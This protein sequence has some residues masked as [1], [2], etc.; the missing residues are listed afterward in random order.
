MK[1]TLQNMFI[2][3]P[4]NETAKNGL[5]TAFCGSIR[6]PD[7]APAAAGTLGWQPL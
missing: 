2:T 1:K 5:K 4:E 6:P 7:P 3:G